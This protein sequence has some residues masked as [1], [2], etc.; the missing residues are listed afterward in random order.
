MRRGTESSSS[1][2]LLYI[3]FSLNVDG[4]VEEQ[5]KW[6]RIPSESFLVNNPIGIWW[7]KI[8]DDSYWRHEE[9]LL[10]LAKLPKSALILTNTSP[11][12]VPLRQNK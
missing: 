6:I 4:G 1:F 5:D 2:I 10:V 12:I 11:L 8:E 7:K 9:I 3:L